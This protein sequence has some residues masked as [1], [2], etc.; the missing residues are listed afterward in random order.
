MQ[1]KNSI[2]TTF[3]VGTVGGMLILIGLIFL[4]YCFIYE[5][6]NKKKLYKEA[7]ILAIVGIVVGILM[8]SLSLLHFNN[9]FS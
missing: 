8:I 4:I 9:S 6:R 3:F 7:K 5:V 2:I 1:N